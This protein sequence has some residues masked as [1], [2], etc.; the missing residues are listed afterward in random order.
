MSEIGKSSK[1]DLH[2]VQKRVSTFPQPAHTGGKTRS[3]SQFV[4]ALLCAIS[5]STDHMS[6]MPRTEKTDMF[7]F[8]ICARIQFQL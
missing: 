1:A 7:S 5:M 2:A 3:T 6:L 8:E 4:I